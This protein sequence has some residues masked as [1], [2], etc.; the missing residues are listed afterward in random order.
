MSRV[1]RSRIVCQAATISPATPMPTLTTFGVIVIAFAASFHRLTH[2]GN[3]VDRTYHNYSCW[4]GY[5]FQAVK[6]TPG[7][8]LKSTK[9]RKLHFCILLLTCD[10]APAIVG[11]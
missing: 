5:I 2:S 9:V 6:G 11:S 1:F 7:G 10:A 4:G 8:K 3:Y